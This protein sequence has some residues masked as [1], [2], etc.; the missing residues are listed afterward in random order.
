VTAHVSHRLRDLFLA[1]DDAAPARR[2]AERVA[3]SSVGVL[4]GPREGG[5]AATA[6]AL[7]LGRTAVVCRW[8]GRDPAPPRAATASLPARRLAERLDRRGLD[9]SAR[10]RLV[11]VALPASPVEARAATERTRAAIDDVPLVLL[12]AGPRPPALD[13]L[14]AALD[15]LVLVP[16]PGAPPGLDD[17][18]LATAAHLGRGAS[19]LALPETP[20]ARLTTSTGRA[21]SPRLRAAARSAL[22]LGGESDA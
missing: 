1:P 3:P 4:A 20:L 5:V 22:G 7:A 21:L 13:P 18:A 19:L 15:R 2:V 9:A 14:L 17:L 12:V 10:G 6:L 11:T 8:D 16:S